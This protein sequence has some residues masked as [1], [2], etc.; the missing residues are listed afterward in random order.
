MLRKPPSF[1]WKAALNA[2]IIIAVVKLDTIVV[3]S[4]L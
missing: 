4:A 1:P 2:E 3:V